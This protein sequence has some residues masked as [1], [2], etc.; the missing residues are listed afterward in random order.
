ME[1][2]ETTVA[3]LSSHSKQQTTFAPVSILS[4]SVSLIL[5]C[6]LCFIILSHEG[7][8]TI[9]SLVEIR[10]LSIIDCADRHI[11][12]SITGSTRQALELLMSQIPASEQSSRPRGRKIVKAAME[13]GNR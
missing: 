1:I 8:A 9:A 7:G 12:T 3:D 5:Y 10:V 2:H 11:L 4:R 6:D 13:V